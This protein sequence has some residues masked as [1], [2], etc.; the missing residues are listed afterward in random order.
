MLLVRRFSEPGRDDLVMFALED[1]HDPAASIVGPDV[2]PETV[3]GTQQTL[4]RPR[5]VEA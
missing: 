4:L 3:E 1:G 2:E 5:I